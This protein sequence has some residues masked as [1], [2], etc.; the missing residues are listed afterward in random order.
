MCQRQFHTSRRHDVHWHHVVCSCGGDRQ[1]IVIWIGDVV[2]VTTKEDSQTVNYIFQT[3]ASHI[4]AVML[5]IT[6]D[7]SHTL[8]RLFQTS[9]L[10]ISAVMIETTKDDSHT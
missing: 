5:E 6:K 4:D 7:D 1:I 3:S 2:M 9:A 10:H 8:N